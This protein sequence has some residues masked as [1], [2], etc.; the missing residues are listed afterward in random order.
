M[1]LSKY[2]LLVEYLVA[3]QVIYLEQ[4]HTKLLNH[5]DIDYWQYHN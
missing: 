5:A 1:F 3:H 4:M 2:G